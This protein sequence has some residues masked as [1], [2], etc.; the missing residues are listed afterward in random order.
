MSL[1][2]NLPTKGILTAQMP[3]IV[4]P[5]LYISEG[6]ALSKRYVEVR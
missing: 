2:S 5:E 1:L 6:E 3:T 4:R